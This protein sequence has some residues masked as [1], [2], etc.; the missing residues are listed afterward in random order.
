MYLIGEQRALT[1]EAANMT[2]DNKHHFTKEISELPND[3]RGGYPNR[4]KSA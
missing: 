4:Y 3:H 1:R 2:R